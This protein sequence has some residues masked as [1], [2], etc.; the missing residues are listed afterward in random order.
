MILYKYYPCDVNTF[1]SLSIKGLWC[2]CPNKMNDPIECLYQIKR[3]FPL[4]KRQEAQN[5]MRTMENPKHCF[6]VLSQC[7][8]DIFD[9]TINKSRIE[10]INSTAF[11]SL[12][13]DPLNILMWSHYANSHQGIVLGIEFDD[14]ELKTNHDFQKVTYSN[15]LPEFDLNTYLD[16]IQNYD[17]S[18]FDS[19]MHMN[20]IFQDMSIKLDC[21]KEEKEWRIWR[22]KPTY[23]CYK[24][25]Q[26]KEIYFGFKCSTEMKGIIV[27]ILSQ[28]LP[29]HFEYYEVEI[30]TNPISLKRV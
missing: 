3:K 17:D 26:I 19:T 13:E 11:C 18:L 27:N 29:E 22:S 28:Y 1:K 25:E 16:F 4:K 2:S 10:L 23:Y 6:S 7:D 30:K 12:S 8:G 9:E 20:S 24:Q 21:W 5:K 14:N 15:N